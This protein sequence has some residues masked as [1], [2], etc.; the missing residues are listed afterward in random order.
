MLALS[1][2]KK[3][4]EPRG[5]GTEQQN[6]VDPL[7]QP[8]S[9]SP[10]LLGDERNVIARSNGT[11]RDHIGRES[12]LAPTAALRRELMRRDGWWLLLLAIARLGK[13]SRF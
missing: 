10:T 6:T 11:S 3:R 1:G 13:N 2:G 8:L 4:N 5:S 9:F 12:G 7:R